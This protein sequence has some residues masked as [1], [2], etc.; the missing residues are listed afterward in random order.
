MWLT[1]CNEKQQH[2]AQWNSATFLAS[3]AGWCLTPIWKQGWLLTEFSELHGICLRVLI[4]TRRIITYFRKCAHVLYQKIKCQ[5]QHQHQSQHCRR[6]PPRTIMAPSESRK[7]KK[8]HKDT[9]AS[10]PPAKK[11]KKKHQRFLKA[12]I[13]FGDRLRSLSSTVSVIR[14]VIIAHTM[15]GWTSGPARSHW[16]SNQEKKQL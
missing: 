1:A 5:H 10:N 6:V 8:W 11:A 15:S 12:N 7:A 4:G 9:D 2:K 13:D 3:D 16:R 14:V